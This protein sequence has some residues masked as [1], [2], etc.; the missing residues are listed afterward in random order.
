LPT[1]A[2]AA[3]VHITV[4][5]SAKFVL[6]SSSVLS[7]P[8]NLTVNGTFTASGTSTVQFNG[9][10]L[11]QIGGAPASFIFYDLKVNNSSGLYLSADIN[12]NNQLIMLSGDFDLRNNNVNLGS[13]GSVSSE[14][15]AKRIKA[16]DGT[17][18]GRGSGTIYTTKTLGI[19]SYTNIAGLGLN[20]TTATNFGA[21]TIKRGHLRQ[22][23]SGDYSSNYSIYR[24]YEIIPT[25]KTVNYGTVT[26]NYFPAFELNGHTDGQLVIFQS[27]NMGG[28]T[29]WTPLSTTNTSPQVVATTVT[30]NLANIKLAVG[31]NSI[32]LP[33]E[34][35]SFTATCTQNP[36]P[37]T[38]HPEPS[39]QQS[40]SNG[41]P[42]QKPTTAILQLNAAPMPNIGK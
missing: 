29:Y 24:Y 22:Q 4:S 41:Q 13:T 33:I 21:T 34:L 16:T 7:V 39:T 9:T 17:T 15:S 30:N 42:P 14:T 31:S 18:D 27:V 11:Q 6:S 40:F 36:A 28:P 10:A 23:G 32:P 25:G 1:A 37:S 20:I 38:Q 2:S 5:S 12:I 8:G 26:I 35:L 19:G 3:S